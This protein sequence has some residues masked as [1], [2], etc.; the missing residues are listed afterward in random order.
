MSSSLGID[1]GKGPDRIKVFYRTQKYADEG[2][3]WFEAL[4]G[5][6]VAFVC[7]E[8]SDPK[9]M[10]ANLPLNEAPE[11]PVPEPLPPE[12]QTELIEKRISQLYMNWA[13]EP[14]PILGDRTPREAIQTPEGLKQVK[15]LLHTY[16]HGEARQAQA[17]HRAPVSYGFLWQSLGIAP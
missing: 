3:P 14:L 5:A 9:G 11:A 15:F 10:L 2:R 8:I 7:R 17:Q 13:D 12:L 16:E 6:A 4:A 1:T